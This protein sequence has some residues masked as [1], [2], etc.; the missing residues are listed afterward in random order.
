MR[1][2]ISRVLPAMFCAALVSA[3]TAACGD[4]DE[5]NASGGSA[6]EV[7]AVATTTQVADFVEQ[8]GGE[9]VRLERLL[10]ANV[11]P[12][13]Y[14]PVPSDAENIA[15]SDVVFRAGFDLDEWLDELIENAGGDRLVVDTSA[16]IEVN[17]PEV[18]GETDPH[19]WLDPRNVPSIVDNIVAGL[20]QVDPEGEEAYSAN[21]ERYKDEVSPMDQ[22]VE[23][24]FAACE[25]DELKLVTNHDSLGHLASRYDLTIVGAII[26][27]FETTAE[28]SADDLAD[29]IRLIEEEDVKAIFSESSLD[30]EIE[31]QVADETGAAVV[32]E[33]YVDAL[34]P[35]DS[36]AATYLEMMI[37]N[38]ETIVD[39]L[40][41]D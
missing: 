37:Y 14:E 22:Q 8:V 3:L 20:V 27:G 5:G 26:P 31:E 12:H 36:E 24:I 18:D 7:Q 33:L 11:D 38:A 17:V 23:E 1:R 39:G 32:A 13:D 15:E 30:T 16:G 40:G 29:L 19:I 6:A 25:P 2:S 34:G 10:D 35:D 4:D 21:A 28:P 9:R 41:C